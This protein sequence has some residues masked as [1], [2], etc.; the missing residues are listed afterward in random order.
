MPFSKTIAVVLLFST[1]LIVSSSVISCKKG[2][3]TETVDPFAGVLNLSSTPFSYAN[4]SLPAQ[5]NTPQ[6]AGQSNTPINN[7]GTDWGAT[8]GR[9][10]FYD[11]NLSVN[12]TISC[13]S[14]HQQAFAFSDPS[15]KSKGFNGGSTG[16]HSMS[17]INSKF[18]PNGRF[19]WDERAAGLEIQTLT[20]IQDAVEMGMTLDALTTKLKTL[21]YYPALFTNAFGDAQINSDRVSKALAQFVR[22]IVSFQSKYDIGRTALGINANPGADFANFTPQENR[23]KQLFFSQQ[24]NCAACHGTETF[25]APNAKNNGLDLVNADKGVGGANNQ[26]NAEGLFKV[27]SLKSIELSAPYMHDGRFKTLEEVIEHYNSGVKA[28]PNLAQQLKDAGGAPVKLNLSAQDK[29]ALVAFLKTLTD[30]QLVTDAKFSN[31]FL[32]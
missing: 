10:L 30:T 29:A 19:F 15:E 21:S 20:P 18:Y 7:T 2:N 9:V 22:S 14:C 3:V 32:K 12:N 27:P 8:L 24:T 6:I 23:G 17:I 25:T 31:P 26:A 28:N 13:S 16:R 1:M 11:K 4:A 5:F